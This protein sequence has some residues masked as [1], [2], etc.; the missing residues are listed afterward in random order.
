M[1]PGVRPGR[2]G[3]ATAGARTPTGSRSALGSPGAFDAVAKAILYRW[4]VER[5]VSTNAAEV[6]S[7][8]AYL[9]TRGILTRAL[10]DGRFH[11]EDATVRTLDAAHL[12]LLA[13]QHV[14]SSRTAARSDPCAATSRTR[15]SPR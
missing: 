10:P 6:E 3:A 11:V 1:E 12:V 13:L 5:D 15:A 14:V 9:H 7:V 4:A 8:R 2:R